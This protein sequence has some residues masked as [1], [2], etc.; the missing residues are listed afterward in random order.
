MATRKNTHKSNRTTTPEPFAASDKQFIVELWR[1]A[2]T[3]ELLAAGQPFVD[4][5]DDTDTDEFCMMAEGL[6]AMYKDYERS[7]QPQVDAAIRYL[8]PST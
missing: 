8:D 5:S 4:E 3:G 6:I 1:K 7:Q 2:L